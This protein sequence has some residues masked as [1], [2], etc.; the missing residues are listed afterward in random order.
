VFGMIVLQEDYTHT[1][2]NPSVC[3]IPCFRRG[4][5]GAPCA[6]LTAPCGRDHPRE[7]AYGSPA[8]QAI[9]I[10]SIRHAGTTEMTNSQKPGQN[11]TKTLSDICESD[12]PP[13]RTR[14]AHICTP[15]HRARQRPSRTCGAAP[16]LASRSTA[17]PFS[18]SSSRP[19]RRAVRRTGATR[20][21]TPF[22]AHESDGRHQKCR[23]DAKRDSAGH[24][25]TL[26]C[27]PVHCDEASQLVRWRLKKSLP[28]CRRSSQ[29]S[30]GL[31]LQARGGLAAARPFRHARSAR[32][33]RRP[34]SHVDA[35]V[36]LRFAELCKCLG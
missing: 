13:G 3:V 19:S 12:R 22:P 2:V 25:G 33:A 15:P 7:C 29:P 18:R 10:D 8:A 36:L 6:P 35:F 31:Q 1:R 23:P 34:R 21:R 16:A 30:L 4:P 32:A 20:P 26:W 14:H 24:M 9:G 28:C 5:D 27:S 17:S 11:A